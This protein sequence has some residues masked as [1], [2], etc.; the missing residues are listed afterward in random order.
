MSDWGA[1]HDGV[2]AA[3]GG[4]DLEMPSGEFMNQKTLMP[5]IKDGKVSMATLDDKV[6]RIL[7][8]AIE[9]GFLDRDQT[10]HTIPLYSQ[11]ARQVAFDAAKDSMVLLKNAGAVLPLD[12]SRIKTVAIV[13]PTAHPAV[14]GGG[15]SSQVTAFRATSYL[16]GISNYLGTG[17]RVLYA[18]D[19]MPG[20]ETFTTTEFVQ[21]IGGESGLKGEYFNNAELSGSPA[22]VRTDSHVAFRWGEGSF[23]QGGPVDHFSARWTGF[24]IPKVAGNYRFIVSGDDGFR[25]YI[26]DQRVL[27]EW[28]RQSETARDYVVRLE[29]GKPYKVK[30]EYYEEVGAASIG[31]GIAPAEETVGKETKA[32]A[33]KSD[34]AIVC[35][36]FDPT[37]ETEGSDRTF[38]L[39]AAQDELIRQIASVN[40][41]TIVVI[42]AGG[43]VDMRNWIDSVPGVINVWY[44]GQEGGTA[45]AQ[46]LFGEFSPSGKLPATFER[47]WQDNP[48][49][50]SYYPEPGQKR[51]AYKEGIFVGYRHF[52]RSNTKPMF[53]FGYGL[54][55]T[56]F[57]YSNLAISPATA[58]GG[59]LA[60]V[61]FE[62]KNV[63][64]REGA[65]VAQ[66]YVGDSHASVPR[67]VKELK[68][69]AKVS[70]KPGESRKVTITLDR[71]AFSYYDVN[72]K[73]WTAEPGEF[74]VL[75]GGSS[76]D[77]ALKG[78]FTLKQ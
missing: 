49:F 61:T 70:L 38:A 59:A 50:G 21:S 44:P 72:R 39:P 51:V 75:V 10:D 35:V 31:L 60:R 2:A 30:L 26:D 17:A 36:G 11:E 18:V 53:P 78:T 69:F 54:S 5:A 65:E 33:A 77:I 71:R 16:E 41:N 19:A 20:D 55:Y 1:T 24:Y 46:M 27:S 62:V 63:G 74:A 76:A 37:T 7:R 40:K 22:L 45:L 66:L 68:G 32:I 47:R 58:D 67:P 14:L 13:G 6:R 8:K 15:G 3:N 34:V 28:Q 43:N 9:F 57:A 56:R 23:V 48:A 73:K 25:L 42:T 52:D 4:L 29:A 12:K 64:S